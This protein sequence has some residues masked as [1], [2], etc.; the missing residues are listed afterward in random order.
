MNK[1][2]IIDVVKGL[3]VAGGPIVAV[4]VNLLGIEAGPAEKIAQGLTALV[5]VAGIVWLAVGRTDRNMVLDAKDIKGV[6][7]HVDTREAPKTVIETARDPSV[8]DVVP[9][10][11]G[12]R[13]DANKQ[14]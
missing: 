9:M 11:G 10:I 3:L 2:Q 14:Q 12:P 5:S 7:V 4:L 1:Q 6:Q 13:N 8:S